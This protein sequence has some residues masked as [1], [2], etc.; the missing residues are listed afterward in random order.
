[1]ASAVTTVDVRIADMEPVMA[2]VKGAAAVEKQFAK[3]TG[4][5]LESLPQAFRDGVHAW[6]D[7]YASYLASRDGGTAE[8]SDETEPHYYGRVIIEWPAPRPGGGM[9]AGWGCKIF[10]ADSGKM[11][12]TV[13]HLA[14]GSSPER[15]IEC[16]M[17]MFA[18]ENGE[19]VRE[20]EPGPRKG[21]FLPVLDGAGNVRTGTF[22]FLVTEMRVGSPPIPAAP[23]P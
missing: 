12:T 16:D 20:L 1:M 11:I 13:S 23:A 15:A 3:L 17:T 14:V 2:L 8:R 5:E 4:A 22:L 18:D 6:R 9:L 19:P 10:D 7:A 21:T